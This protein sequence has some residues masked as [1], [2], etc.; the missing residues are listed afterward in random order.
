MKHKWFSLTSV[1][2]VAILLITACGG[3]E[4]ATATPVPVEKEEPTEAP[5]ATEA[6]EP[7]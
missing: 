7:T 4:E 5:E 2:M 6:P 3:G 1:L